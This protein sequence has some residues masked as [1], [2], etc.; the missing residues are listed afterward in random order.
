MAHR[1][2]DDPRFAEVAA[3][4]KRR[5]RSLLS[6]A[7]FVA[8]VLAA[9]LFKSNFFAIPGIIFWFVG[10]YNCLSFSFS[11]CPFCGDR[12]SFYSSLRDAFDPTFVFKRYSLM[13]N[14]CI[15]CGAGDE[16]ARS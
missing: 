12:W 13:G 7:L 3:I 10:A 8:S 5:D 4:L 2:A 15:N 14:R 1:G 6:F 11:K 9:V 16:P